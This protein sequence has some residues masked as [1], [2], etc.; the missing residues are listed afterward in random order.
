[1]EADHATIR[2]SG[3]EAIKKYVTDPLGLRSRVV[4][5]M[6]GYTAVVYDNSFFLKVYRQ[7][8]TGIHPDVEMTAFFTTRAPLS[9]VPTMAGKVEW[10]TG[11]E[12]LT[13]AMAQDLVEFHGNGTTYMLDR[14]NNFND[15][16]LARTADQLPPFDITGT[17]SN[18]LSYESMPESLQE[19]LGV[20][21]AE[22][23]RQIGEAWASIHKALATVV[24]GAAFTPENFSLH[25]QRSLYAGLQS[26]V[27]SAFDNLSRK[28]NTLP[29]D[30]Q[31]QARDLMGKKEEVLDFFK[32]I[33]SK[34]LDIIKTRIH[35]YSSLE[36]VLFTGRD[37][38]VPYLGGDPSRSFSERRL[39]R[40]PF[41]D[42]AAMVRSFYYVAQQALR[43]D[44]IKADD[45]PVLTRWYQWWT[46]YA[47]MLFM[48]AYLDTAGEA[49]FI[50]QD[51]ED[52]TTLLHIY[53]LEIA[54]HDLNEELDNRPDWVAV[55]LHLVLAIL[56][57]NK[58]PAPV[59]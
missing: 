11:K 22:G 58:H 6:A 29:A 52:L 12:Q 38:S 51:K 57:E 32:K 17:L 13:L 36:Q 55:P 26:L 20:P 24:D 49:P 14:L 53:L 10:T 30:I 48:Q 2:F 23:A 8:E 33:Y 47:A 15:K 34:K 39:K 27:R 18:P 7:V 3:N 45:L 19:I 50:P 35:G 59:D 9:V 5:S 4:P 40:S 46:H 16:V 21:L 1:V 31:P 43:S 56:Q 28:L 41:R 25:Y 37:V 54:V 42:V 44:R